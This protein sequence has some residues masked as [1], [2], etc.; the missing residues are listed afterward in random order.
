MDSA[1][2]MQGLPEG[3]RRRR[4]RDAGADMAACW[5]AVPGGGG[6]QTLR[7]T[8]TTLPMMVARSPEMGG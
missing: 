2:P 3:S 8:A 7:S 6:P 5:R 4:P 1:R